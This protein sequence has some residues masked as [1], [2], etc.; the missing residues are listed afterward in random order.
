MKISQVIETLKKIKETQGDIEVACWPYDGQ[1][2]YY[3]LTT[4]EIKNVE[5][6]NMEKEMI[7]ELDADQPFS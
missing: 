7:V 6:E 1:G 2:R 5:K 4:I 3:H